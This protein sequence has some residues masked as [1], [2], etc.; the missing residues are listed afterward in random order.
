VSS[1]PP[2]RRS[3]LSFLPPLIREPRRPLLVLLVAWLASIAGSLLIAS[4]IK[5]VAAEAE[6]PNFDWLIGKGFFAIFILS[7]ATPLLETLILAATTGLLLR[8]VSPLYAI[9][10]SSF[11]WALAHSYQT[12]V[13]GL[14]ICWPFIIFTTLF[15]VWKQRSLAWGIVMPWLAHALQNLFPAIAIGYPGL[16]PAVS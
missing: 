15:I 1:A 2:L 10:L 4:I 14:V 9:L 16:L 13:W 3:D 5:L 12:P 7:L 11:G 8:F 6:A